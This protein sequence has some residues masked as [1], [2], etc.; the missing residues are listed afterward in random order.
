MRDPQKHGDEDCSKQQP[1]HDH[2][3][4]THPA[5]ILLE[6]ALLAAHAEKGPADGT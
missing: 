4:R 3:T 6:Q 2:V 1:D 5:Q